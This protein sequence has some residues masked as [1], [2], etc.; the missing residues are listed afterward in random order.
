MSIQDFSYRFFF[1]FFVNDVDILFRND[2]FSCCREVWLLTLF[3][4]VSCSQ[5]SLRLISLFCD[6]TFC[7]KHGLWFHIY[8]LYAIFSIYYF[9]SK[10]NCLKYYKLF[11]IFPKCIIV[12]FISVQ[13]Y[14]ILHKNSFSQCGYSTFRINFSYKDLQYFAK[15]L[16]ILTLHETCAYKVCHCL[17][18]TSRCV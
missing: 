14:T 16:L 9:K 1:F 18:Y 4:L 5:S 13:I 3:F 2:V 12:F 11:L 8:T 7:A 17:L 10:V 6:M 15:K